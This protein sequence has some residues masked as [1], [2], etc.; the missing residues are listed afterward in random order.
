MEIRIEAQLAP[1]KGGWLARVPN[2]K[3]AR[4]GESETQALAALKQ[5]V[6]AYCAGLKRDGTLLPSLRRKGVE[7]A[8]D[9]DA[10]CEVVLLP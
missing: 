10:D 8:G 9:P 4:A 6:V 5:T 3:L 2:L 1:I 7:V